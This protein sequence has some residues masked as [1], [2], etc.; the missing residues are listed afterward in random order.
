[1]AVR[2][3]QRQAPSGV[4][5]FSQGMK[6]RF[7]DEDIFLMSILIGRREAIEKRG[8]IASL[9]QHAI[10]DPATDCTMWNVMK[11]F[12]AELNCVRQSTNGGRHDQLVRF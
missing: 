6:N 4:L 9:K 3:R 1:M 10:F 7:G 2:S 5:R 12:D 11:M 8:F